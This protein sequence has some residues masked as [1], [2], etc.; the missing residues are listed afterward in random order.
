MLT[1]RTRRQRQKAIHAIKEIAKPIDKKT[2]VD[3]HPPPSDSRSESG[4]K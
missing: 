4:E 3:L 1:K 2:E